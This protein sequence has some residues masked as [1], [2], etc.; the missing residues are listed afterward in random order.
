MGQSWE[1]TA[2]WMST[3]SLFLRWKIIVIL[4]ILA[5]PL[6]AYVG[7]YSISQVDS[8]EG[9]LNGKYESNLQEQE[10]GQHLGGKSLI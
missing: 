3:P 1:R 2:Y 8:Q 6:L 5:G 10:A 7:L 9:E 4:R